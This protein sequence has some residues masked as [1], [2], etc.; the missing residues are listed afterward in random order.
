MGSP[1][2]M[3]EVSSSEGLEHAVG[4]VGR[5]TNLPTRYEQR[6]PREDL[7]A[8]LFMLALIGIGS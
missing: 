6:L 7:A 1:Y 2:E 4:E 5:M 3:F 8:P